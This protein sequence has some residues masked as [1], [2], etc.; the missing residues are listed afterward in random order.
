MPDQVRHDDEN[1]AA[2]LRGRNGLAFA[3]ENAI[4]APDPAPDTFWR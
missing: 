2:A 1:D 3:G 4:A